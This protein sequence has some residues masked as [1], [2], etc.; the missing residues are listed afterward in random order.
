MTVIVNVKNGLYRK[1]TSDKRAC[2]AYSAA[3][4]EINEIV[5]RKPVTYRKLYLL[6]VCGGVENGSAAFLFLVYKI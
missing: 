2:R 5:D 1:N 3:S 4:F 6:G